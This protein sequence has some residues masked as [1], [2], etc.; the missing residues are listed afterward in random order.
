MSADTAKMENA[1]LQVMEKHFG[2]DDF[3]PTTWS[4][5][6]RTA[7]GGYYRFV[8]L[9]RILRRGDWA[10]AATYLT[11]ALSVNPS[12]ATDMD[13]FYE[14]ALGEQPIGQRGR[15]EGL[16]L[17]LNADRL[18]KTLNAVF[19]SSSPTLSSLRSSVMS[20]AY[21][22]LGLLAYNTGQAKRS[23]RY[24]L[25]ALGQRPALLLNSRFVG[26]LAR[27]LMV[28]VVRN[29]FRTQKHS[30]SRV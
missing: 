2:R 8:A 28:A 16:N 29:Q 27:S 5:D 1:A 11:N 4:F 25:K 21:W 12:L 26:T 19:A 14:L 15:A 3:K 22:C 13:L 24:L 30:A 7:Y 23:L 20:T 6:K 10:N 18:A 9:T 17:D